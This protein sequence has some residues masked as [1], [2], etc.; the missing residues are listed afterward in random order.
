MTAWLL[1][2]KFRLLNKL[3]I[4]Q[5]FFI[6]GKLIIILYSD[7]VRLLRKVTRE[8]TKYTVTFDVPDG[9]I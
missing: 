4:F 1:V 8:T 5:I 3:F 6:F 7:L 9:V 2:S